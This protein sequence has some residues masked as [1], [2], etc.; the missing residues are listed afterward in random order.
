MCRPSSGLIATGE[1][2]TPAEREDGQ[3]Q[4]TALLEW[5]P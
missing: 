1:R 4:L 5:I 3:Q 2:L